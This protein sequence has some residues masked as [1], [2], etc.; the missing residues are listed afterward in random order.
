MNKL[1]YRVLSEERQVSSG[2]VEKKKESVIVNAVHFRDAIAVIPYPI[3]DA[4]A[5]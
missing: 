5:A 3:E 2:H 1:V 4:L